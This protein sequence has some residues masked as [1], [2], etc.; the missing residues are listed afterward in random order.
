MQSDIQHAVLVPLVA[1]W[2]GAADRAR[3]SMTS[4]SRRNFLQELRLRN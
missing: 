2:R 4:S 3:G 1:G